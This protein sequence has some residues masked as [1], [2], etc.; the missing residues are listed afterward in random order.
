MSS[1]K[2]QIAGFDDLF[3]KLNAI[4]VG[5]RGGIVKNAMNQAGRIV[6]KRA[7]ELARKPGDAG[8]NPRSRQRQGNKHLVDT[9]G[10]V[11]RFYSS[12]RFNGF[13]LV[14]GPEYPAGAHGH[15]VEYGHRLAKP[16]T[17][18]LARIAKPGARPARSTKVHT[19]IV[20]GSTRP[21]PFM[22]PAADDSINKISNTIADAVERAIAKAVTHG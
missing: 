1:V 8:Y 18:T 12:T 22:K 17:G 6:A 21:F 5:L 20:S 13:V 10:Q 2:I 15:L 11:V 7:K 16:G 9:I 3:R 19:G 14:V 4:S